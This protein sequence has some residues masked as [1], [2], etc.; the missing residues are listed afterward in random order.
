VLSQLDEVALVQGGHDEQDE[1]GAPGPGLGELVPGDEEV[2]AEHGDVDPAPDGGEVVEAAREPAALGED[3][4]GGGAARGVLRGERGGVV[5]VGQGALAGAGPLD[6][7]DDRH[8]RPRPQG[9]LGVQGGR[10]GR[11]ATLELG[12]GDGRH[13]E[14]QVLPDAGDDVVQHAAGRGR[15][16]GRGLVGHVLRLRAGRGFGGRRLVDRRVRSAVTDWTLSLGGAP[17]CREATRR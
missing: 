12:L 13:S 2:L 3:A 16:G 11:G 1:V 8:A 17:A 10:G 4:H 7:G 6:L 5:D 15:A 9:G 14:C